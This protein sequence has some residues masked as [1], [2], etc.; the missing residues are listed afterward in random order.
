[1]EPHSSKRL[2]LGALEAAL[3]EYLERWI[4][5]D[6]EAQERLSWFQDAV[7]RSDSLEGS[8]LGFMDL[9]N[10]PLPADD[11]ERLEEAR[12][13]VIIIAAQFFFLGWNARGAIEDAG[14]MKGL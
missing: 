3:S 10:E 14:R 5:S 2:D 11:V 9:F 13:R 6:E 12:N 1:M 4:L 7:K 8:I